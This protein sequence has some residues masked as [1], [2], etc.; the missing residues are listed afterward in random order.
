MKKQKSS[1]S[2]TKVSK[3]GNKN[4]DSKR[5]LLPSKVKNEM[6]RVTSVSRL[7]TNSALK[8]MKGELPKKKTKTASKQSHETKSKR[9]ASKKAAKSPDRKG[10]IFGRDL[11][12]STNKSLSRSGRLSPQT[13]LRSKVSRSRSPTKSSNSANKK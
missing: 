10:S 12:A 4:S 7:T 6:S 11:P 5:S 1:A 2:L 3:L 9:S 8:D 13:T